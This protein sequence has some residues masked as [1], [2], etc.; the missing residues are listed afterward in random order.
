LPAATS[1]KDL[2]QKPHEEESILSA[3]TTGDDP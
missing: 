1:S 3:R 2:A